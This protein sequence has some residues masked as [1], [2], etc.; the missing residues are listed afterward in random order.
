MLVSEF[1]SVYLKIF[2]NISPLFI[3]L[4]Q[5]IPSI[6]LACICSNLSSKTI[7]ENSNDHTFVLTLALQLLKIRSTYL[8]MLLIYQDVPNTRLV[9]SE[10]SSLSL[11]ILGQNQ[12]IK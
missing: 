10:P 7:L 8:R 5:N 9:R 11:L 3:L 2:A 1:I 6:Y 12:D 4:S